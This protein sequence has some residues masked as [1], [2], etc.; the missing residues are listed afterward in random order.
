MSKQEKE[1]PNEDDTF[2]A[3][4]RTPFNEFI[5]AVAEYTG[6]EEDY[7]LW[8]WSRATL[9]PGEPR[10]MNGAFYKSHGWNWKDMVNEAKRRAFGP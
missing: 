6:D 10:L 5:K 3:L 7:L 9:G 8:I 4:T 2:R 1:E